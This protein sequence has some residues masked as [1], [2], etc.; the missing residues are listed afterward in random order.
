MSRLNVVM[1]SPK[2]L[3]GAAMDQWTSML[4]TWQMVASHPEWSE[5]G[6]IRMLSLGGLAHVHGSF[7]WDGIDTIET[8]TP[9]EM[10]S[11]LLAV[12]DTIGFGKIAAGE[13]VITLHG[14]AAGKVIVTG[15]YPILLERL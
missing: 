10:D 7:E 9:A 5:D 3:N 6:T 8:D 14:L 2:P 11:V 1:P 15:W 4:S 13:S 12:G